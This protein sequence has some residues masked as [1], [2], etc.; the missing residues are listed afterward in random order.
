Q[1]RAGRKP[2]AFAGYDEALV[3]VGDLSAQDLQRQPGTDMG[4]SAGVSGRIGLQAAGQGGAEM[5]QPLPRDR[6][7]FA[8]SGQGAGRGAQ[9]IAAGFPGA[10]AATP[11]A[12]ARGF[13]L[14]R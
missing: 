6:E 11:T 12:A 9:L 10:A 4:E 3:G 5:I 7:Q 13:E 2:D 1:Q 14:A 8:R